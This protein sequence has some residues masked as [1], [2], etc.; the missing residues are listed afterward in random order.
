MM[1]SLQTVQYIRWCSIWISIRILF[2]YY[3]IYLSIVNGLFNLSIIFGLKLSIIF[4]IQFDNCVQ[5]GIFSGMDVRFFFH[6]F[7]V[8]NRS[9]RKCLLTGRIDVNQKLILSDVCGYFSDFDDLNYSGFFFVFE[10]LLV[11]VSC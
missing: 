7:I 6:V 9:S 8:R 3:R 1:T 11:H 4:D 10:A 2:S 5:H